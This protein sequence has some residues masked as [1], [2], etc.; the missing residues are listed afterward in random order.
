LIRHL[1]PFG[2]EEILAV[3]QHRAFTIEWDSV[4]L[5][6][7]REPVPKPFK[8]V[9]QV[10]VRWEV[11]QRLRG[12][13]YVGP[14]LQQRVQDAVA[15]LQ[16]SPN[17]VAASLRERRSRMIGVVVPDITMGL[18]A[19][20][21]RRLE[22]RAAFTD[23][24]LVLADGQ[25]DPAWERERVRAL[26]R[27]KIDALIIIPCRDDSPV[28]EDV[29]QSGIPT[30]LL[31]RVAKGSDFDHVLLDSLAA[32]REGTRHLIS[33]GHRR[34]LLL[35]SDP[36]LRNIRERIAGYRA[37]LA[38]ANLLEFENIVVAGCNQAEDARQALLP[39]L[40]G[41]DRPS[42]LFAV[43][44]TMTIGA[45]QSLWEAGLELPKDISL[46][47]FDDSAWFTALRPF[48]STVRQPADDFADL[49]WAMLMAR[50][51]NDRSPALQS[52]VHADLVIRDSTIP[53]L[54]PLVTEAVQ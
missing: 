51:N 6:L 5:A 46:L 4:Q 7:I 22:K 31:D 11:L 39:V 40:T 19:A 35:A 34:I 25:E 2:L 43:T 32:A 3:H 41:S 29:Q 12:T 52:E 15:T 44:Q 17:S 16:Y 27:R 47:A 50:L 8:N 10:I 23:Y 1:Q 14:Q 21:V 13:R 42:A 33:L 9:F 24:Q 28:L 36:S 54:G 49:A 37:A 45:L 20:I 53:Y 26:I 18:F 48:V 30:V 38:D